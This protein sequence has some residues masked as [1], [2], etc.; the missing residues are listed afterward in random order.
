MDVMQ[1]KVS[2]SQREK[3]VPSDSIYMCYLKPSDLW[4][5]KVDRWLQGLSGGEMGYIF[6][7][8]EFQFCMMTNFL[9][10]MLVMVTQRCE[11]FL[12]QLNCTLRP[13]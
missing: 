12:T 11:C 13:G 8:V 7:Q 3:Y 10:Y 6:Q 4:R 2:Q 1:S 9:R 5:G